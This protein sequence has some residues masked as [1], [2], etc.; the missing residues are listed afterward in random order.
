MRSSGSSDLKHARDKLQ[1][2]LQIKITNAISE[3]FA[4]FAQLFA[5]LSID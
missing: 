2:N 5:K 1:I 3:S 4:S